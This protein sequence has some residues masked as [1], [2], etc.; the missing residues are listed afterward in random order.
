MKRALCLLL[1]TIFIAASANS[2]SAAFF[3][4]ISGHWGEFYIDSAAETGVIVGFPNGAFKPE[5]TLTKGQFLS[6]AS[7]LYKLGSTV[8]PAGHWASDHY[9]KA[10]AKQAIPPTWNN[11]TNLDSPVTR[12]DMA[13]IVAKLGNFI[14]EDSPVSD[15]Q[16]MFS[17]S[18]SIAEYAMDAVIALTGSMI[19]TGMGNGKFEPKSALTRVQ[20]C[21]IATKILEFQ[22]RT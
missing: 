20:A 21:V 8:S 12:E 22:N 6:V 11:R 13:F 10:F 4:D 14:Y 18:N 3:M 7:N 5:A 1:V 15:G 16:N 19:L 9:R 2:V 17:D